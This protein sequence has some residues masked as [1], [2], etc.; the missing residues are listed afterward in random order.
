MNTLTEASKNFANVFLTRIHEL[1][2]VAVEWLD[3][4]LVTMN[5]PG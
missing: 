1:L 3:D 5:Q 4:Q 2:Q